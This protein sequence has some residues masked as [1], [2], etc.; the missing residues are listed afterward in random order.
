MEINLFSGVFMDFFVWDID[1]III[2]FGFL[3]VRWYSLFFVG[4]FLLGYLILKKIF[5]KE[6][7]DPKSLDDLLIWTLLGAVV[8]ARLF[9]T[10]VYEPD[11]YL[12]HPL[13]ILYIWEGGLASHGGMIGVLIVLYIYS[14]KMNISYIWLLSRVALPASLVA[15]SIRVGNFFNS[16]ILGKAT[17]LP[18]GVIF[19]RVD[20]TPRHP[21]Q[22]Y[23]AFSYLVIGLILWVLYKRLDKKISSKLIL[24][25]F[26]F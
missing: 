24:A 19:S 1:P 6:N 14:K 10:L 18:W 5:E 13:K 7:L 25:L 4:S 17:E 20:L 15:F 26:L 12:S 2:K 21:V 3:Q 16:E 8:G 23:E 9:H 11:F 22:L